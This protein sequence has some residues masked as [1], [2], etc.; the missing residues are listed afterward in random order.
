MEGKK[1][2]VLGSETAGTL[3]LV[4]YGAN[5]GLD[6]IVA[7]LVGEFN[8]VIQE[9]ALSAAS[10]VGY[11]KDTLV[12]TGTG[13]KLTGVPVAEVTL[14]LSG[15][16]NCSVTATSDGTATYDASQVGFKLNHL[17][18]C[19]Q[20]GTLFGVLTVAGVPS[21]PPVRVG[22]VKQDR[23]GGSYINTAT[24]NLLN[25]AVTLEVTGVNLQ[26]A[27]NFK[28][29][30]VLI[31]FSV[32]QGVAPTAKS[33]SWATIA[34]NAAMTD[35]LSIQ[36]DGYRNSLAGALK[37]TIWIAGHLVSDVNGT[38]VATVVT[39]QVI[40]ASSQQVAANAAEL[41]VSGHNLPLNQGGACH[42]GYDD[43]TWITIT[44][45]VFT[46]DYYLHSCGP[47]GFIL[48][49]VDSG[50]T[51]GAAG[52]NIVMTRYA[53]Q[54]LPASVVIGKAISVVTGGITITNSLMAPTQRSIEITGTGFK[55]S[56]D[57]TSDDISVVFSATGLGPNGGDKVF[58]GSV[59]SAGYSNTKM[60]VYSTQCGKN[61]RL[62]TWRDAKLSGTNS[63]SERE[64]VDLMA[65]TPLSWL[66]CDESWMGRDAFMGLQ[67]T[68]IMVNLTIAGY[69]LPTTPKK[70]HAEYVANI[71]NLT[72]LDPIMRKLPPPVMVAAKRSISVEPSAASIATNAGS[73]T[74]QGQNLPSSCGMYAK[75]IPAMVGHEAP[76]QS[77]L[78]L[79][80]NL[81]L[82]AGVDYTLAS[83]TST[84]LVLTLKSGKVWGAAGNTLRVGSLGLSGTL[85]TSIGTILSFV[86]P[87]VTAKVTP[88]ANTMDR[89]S[90]VGSGL[91]PAGLTEADISVRVTVERGISPIA[92]S[93]LPGGWSNTGGVVVL[94][95]L[96]L[97]RRGKIW[98]VVSVAGKEAVKKQI[99]TILEPATV[100]H[101]QLRIRRQDAS[102][103]VSGQNLPVTCPETIV[104]Q[105]LLFK[106]HFDVKECTRT[107]FTLT[108]SPNS[109]WGITDS[110]LRLVQYGT[111]IF[112]PSVRLA[113]LIDNTIT[114]YST[115]SPPSSKLRAVKAVLPQTAR[116]GYYEYAFAEDL[117]SQD[118]AG[119]KITYSLETVNP[120]VPIPDWLKFDDEYLL[121]HGQPVPSSVIGSVPV[122][123]L[124]LVAR[125][126][127]G[128]RA[129]VEFTME[130][131][132][133]REVVNVNTQGFF[134]TE[135]YRFSLDGQVDSLTIHNLAG[136]PPMAK[137]H[138]TAWG[139][140]GRAVFHSVRV[141]IDAFNTK[142]N[143]WE[144]IWTRDIQH[145]ETFSFEGLNI[146]T[147]G[148]SV[149]GLRWRSD[150]PQD[151]TFHHWSN[152]G[153][154]FSMTT[155]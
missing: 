28:D 105:G 118:P 76:Q 8:G 43:A 5:T 126:E 74:I 56:N 19:P 13:I 129:A 95:G 9:A 107:G 12:V 120:L 117:F 80:S 84:Q 54:D 11:D 77:V 57:F 27:S 72:Q 100:P 148:R 58:R 147:H 103:T 123:E 97:S 71:V 122:Q 42:N 55:P 7:S 18:S 92:A 113:W 128:G 93:L 109:S 15:I 70:V 110:Q 90:V 20:G 6:V 133:E 68:D 35:K 45:K 85:D 89:V 32:A 132:H 145:D 69:L 50:K 64:G 67:A 24:A 4:T 17:A 66:E 41:V 14:T 52:A 153:L 82:V 46:Q 101:S 81:A 60:V 140:E 39:P 142:T 119:G 137:A 124:A 37:A 112:E 65:E 36:L 152:V 94:S 134:N 63:D 73:I 33:W 151:Y 131:K 104:L 78:T 2:G 136:D 48:R 91:L 83:C 141:S 130:V 75:L 22:R 155:D 26:T 47:H 99:G 30:D 87:T 53:A 59:A 146:K 144:E 125:D 127:Q 21:G 3:K 111:T 25:T 106:E 138:A 61:Q 86:S 96:A 79:S 121:M 114:P 23:R 16:S 149:S 1:W 116:H 49:L 108:L 98:A 102:F 115:V 143:G 88:L 62:R 31:Q 135:I 29:S 51:W 10:D 139:E 40:F 154:T 34:G 150:P 44:G 38:V